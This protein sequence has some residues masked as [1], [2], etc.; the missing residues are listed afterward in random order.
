VA[1]LN[2][3]Q[4]RHVATIQVDADKLDAELGA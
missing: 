3:R 2:E 4:R 1:F